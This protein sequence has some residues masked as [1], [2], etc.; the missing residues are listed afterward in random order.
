MRIFNPEIPRH[1]KLWWTTALF[2]YFSEHQ[3]IRF[4]EAM[5]AALPVFFPSEHESVEPF[6]D[7]QD[8]ADTR[9][10]DF[11]LFEYKSGLFE[12]K[13]VMEYF[14][15]HGDLAPEEFAYLK[16]L[17]LENIYSAFRISEHFINRGWRMEDLLTG[18]MYDVSEKLGT[19][20]TKT[21]DVLC[22]RIIPKQEGGWMLSPAQFVMIPMDIAIPMVN[23]LL[24]IRGKGGKQEEFTALELEKGFFAKKEAADKKIFM[25]IKNEIDLDATGKKLGALLARYGSDYKEEEIRKILWE[26]RTDNYVDNISAVIDSFIKTP[27]KDQLM[28][29][30]ELWHDFSNYTP[31]KIFGGKTPAEKTREPRPEI[32][33]LEKTL[34]EDFFKTATVFFDEH[35]YPSQ[36]VSNH[37][38]KRFRQVWL[39][40][41]QSALNGKTAMQAIL[42]ERKG[43][44][45]DETDFGLDY[46]CTPIGMGRSQPVSLKDIRAD[47]IVR[48]IDFMLEYISSQEYTRIRLDGR[49]GELRKNDRDNII[50]GVKGSAAYADLTDGGKNGMD[51]LDFL[52]DLCFAARLVK[53][54]WLGFRIHKTNYKA[55]VRKTTGEKLFELFSGWYFGGLYIWE[56]FIPADMMR[57][58]YTML[59]SVH[60]MENRETA[61]CH[62]DSL[63]LG[64]E[65]FENFFYRFYASKKAILEKD[66]TQKTQLRKMI[67]YCHVCP[68]VMFGLAKIKGKD[69]E[70][71]PETIALT[72]IGKDLMPHIID[73]MFL[74]D[75]DHGIYKEDI[76]EFLKY[77]HPDAPISAIP[78]AFAVG[79][80][81]PCPCGSGKKYKKCCLRRE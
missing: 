3:D 36:R 45:N 67:Y 2:S 59:Q 54:D 78:P 74:R 38:A 81:T 9:F 33:T 5:E 31:R 23:G 46:F 19:R 48:D 18:K 73:E 41:P 53:E 16:R 13:T 21:G 20:Q 24:R 65:K 30:M 12:N 61:L 26:E 63:S 79:R 25:E 43:L 39:D 37:V 22:G 8:M 34:R 69:S 14:E 68:F 76:A 52:V 27:T 62:F 17:N 7:D 4:R 32:G 28:E 40:T 60:F 51:Y 11:F 75:L 77:H 70:G 1:T 80:N 66:I 15:K 35:D 58:D 44:G 47:A 55:Y 72:E 50:A 42:N 10:W 29:F 57:S 64:K 6:S 56:Y 71:L 49:S